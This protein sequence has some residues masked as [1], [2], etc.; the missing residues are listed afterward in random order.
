MWASYKGHVTVVQEYLERGA[1]PNVKAEVR[2]RHAVG[3]TFL[4]CRDYIPGELML[5]PSCWRRPLSASV[6]T[7]AQCLSFQRCAYF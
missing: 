2:L 4:A 3:K 5:S 6:S 7:L 1:D